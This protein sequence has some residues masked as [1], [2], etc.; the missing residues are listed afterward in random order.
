MRLQNAPCGHLAFDD[1]RRI[2]A[3]NDETQR[4]LGFAEGEL[5]G[6]N[7]GILLPTAVRMLFHTTVYPVLAEGKRAEEVYALLRCKS[8]DDLPVLLNAARHLEEG[9]Y[10][11]DC[12][13]MAVKRRNL[14]ERHLE[15]LEAKAEAGALPRGEPGAAQ[16][17]AEAREFAERMSTLGLLLAGV[18]HEV[19][20][21]LAYVHG[22]LELLRDELSEAREP[23]WQ[24]ESAQ[25]CV[26]E[27]QSGVAQILELIDAVSMS[28]RAESVGPT[29]V[30][31]ARV[32]DR[33]V[34]LVHH[35]VISSAQLDVT[36]PPSTAQA[37]AEEPRLA[38]VVMNLLI[39][40]AQALKA[41]TRPTPRIRVSHY[42]AQN[43]AVIEISDNGPGVPL[44]LR[45]R[46][47]KP[48]FT[49]KPIG[50][51]T[52]LGLAISRQIVDSFGGSLELSSPAEGGATFRIL[53]PLAR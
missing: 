29:S 51:G 45:E 44:A 38:Q 33:A 2:T 22:N 6:Q 35:R 36:S 5:L 41:Q 49:T 30:D 15:R 23:G 50:E 7:L 25:E 17:A 8:G 14:F 27:A 13:F 12:V 1:N 39:N 47:F 10:R 26:A 37:L 31:V 18:M 28:S 19:R 32:V 9:E 53:L 4:W 34:R 52:G 46:I 43:N 40:A 20:N 21:P 24:P 3:V 48:F 11:T 16:P 42:V